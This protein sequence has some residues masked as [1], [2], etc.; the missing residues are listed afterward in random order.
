MNFMQDSTQK[1]LKFEQMSISQVTVCTDLT[2]VV[3]ERYLG[4]ATNEYAVE[5]LEELM[6]AFEAKI[7]CHGPHAK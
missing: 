5:V 2:N 6:R 1:P 7:Q 3:T 4:L